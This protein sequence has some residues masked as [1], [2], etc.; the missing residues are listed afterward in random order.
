MVWGVQNSAIPKVE[1]EKLGANCPNGASAQSMGPRLT[2]IV[3]STELLHRHGDEFSTAEYL[4]NAMGCANAPLWQDVVC[5]WQ[6]IYEP[7]CGVID[8]PISDQS[9]KDFGIRYTETAAGGRPT[10]VTGLPTGAGG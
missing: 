2:I 3:T 7:F 5:T 1:Q 10:A 4:M 9:Y 8:D 6:Q